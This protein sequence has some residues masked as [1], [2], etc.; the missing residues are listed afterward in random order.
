LK[1]ASSITGVIVADDD[2]VIRGILRSKLAA[3]DQ[4]VFLAANGEEAV[5]L[6]SGI[7]AAMVILDIKMPRLN[8]LD[9]CQFIRK[10]PG[11]AQTPIVIL[12]ASDEQGIE[13]TAARAGATA[14]LTKPFRG[15]SLLEMLARFL[16]MDAATLRTIQGDA[17]RATRIAQGGPAPAHNRISTPLGPA[18][19]LDRSTTIL[20]VL[21]G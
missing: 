7:Q 21:R 18:S 5:A 10:L 2:P 11:Y 1:I 20:G 14:F 12:T 17:D 15:A 3:I 4:A 9:A 6:A 19:A 13:D 8:G 16:P